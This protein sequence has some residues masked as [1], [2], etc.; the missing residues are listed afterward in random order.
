[1]EQETREK[2][3]Q[4]PEVLFS[5]DSSSHAMAPAQCLSL[6]TLSLH[7]AP[8]LAVTPFLQSAMPLPET[9]L[10]AHRCKQPSTAQ[11]SINSNACE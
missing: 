11:R 2:D 6:R 8:C 4:D 10:L 7:Q 1:M 3:A 5:G 9:L